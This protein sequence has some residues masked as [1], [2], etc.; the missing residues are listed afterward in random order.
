MA[1]KTEQQINDATIQK[2]LTANGGEGIAG[3]KAPTPT[4]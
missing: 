4:S 2:N 1:T 3:S